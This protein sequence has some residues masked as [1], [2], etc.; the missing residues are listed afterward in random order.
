[1]QF[2]DGSIVDLDVVSLNFPDSNLLLLV[3]VDELNY[4]QRFL[5][6]VVDPEQNKFI[7]KMPDFNQVDAFFLML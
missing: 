7:R 1:M 6:L 2:L 4:L 5:L 3:N